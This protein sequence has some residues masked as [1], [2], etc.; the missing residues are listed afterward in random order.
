[1]IILDTNVVSEPLK[2]EPSTSV[3]EWLNA[4]DMQT[5]YLTTI[6][7]AELLSGVETLPMG[8]RRTELGK[9][10]TEE[11]LPLFEDR[12]LS[13]DMKS[14]QNFARLNAKAQASGNPISFADCAIAAIAESHAF[15]IATRNVKDFKGTGV[16]ILNPWDLH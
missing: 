9:K 1:M 10:V 7:V 11:I 12:I 8:K 14:A 2:R 15:Q 5:L 4:Q 3:L 13:F 6:T 16:G